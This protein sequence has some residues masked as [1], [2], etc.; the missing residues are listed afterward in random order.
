[1]I[2]RYPIIKLPLKCRRMLNISFD[3]RL[4]TNVRKAL[5]TCEEF[6]EVQLH[7]EWPLLTSKQ[8]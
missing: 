1:M 7:F 2:K 3:Q 8:K 5:F 6:N 4:K